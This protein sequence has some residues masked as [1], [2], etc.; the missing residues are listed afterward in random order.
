MFSIHMLPAA[1]GDCLW[2][3]YGDKNDPCRVLVDTGTPGTY[4]MLSQKIAP[5]RNKTFELFVVSHIDNDHIGGAIPL[6]ENPPHGI[7]FKD[8]WFNGFRHLIKANKDKLGFNQGQE[9]TQALVEGKH[10]WN[11]AFKC[12][13]V[14]VPEDGLLP[15]SKLDGN[16]KLTLLSPYPAQLEALLPDWKKA[17]IKLRKKEPDLIDDVAADHLGAKLN[18]RSLAES[19]FKEDAGTPNGS[20]I[21]FLAEYGSRAVLFGADAFPG[22]IEHSVDRLLAERKLRKLPLDAF[23]VCHHGSRHNTS[24]TLPAKLRAER[25]LISSDGTRHEHPHREGVARLVFYG[26]PGGTLVFNYATDYNRIWNDTLLKKDHKYKTAI[27]DKGNPG[28]LI[29]L[30]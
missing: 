24:P 12:G 27:P 20:S 23:K 30:G 13:P 19:P 4:E 16:L 8:V 22:V 18:I 11:K 10:P 25:Y 21:A 7:K 6:L 3:E 14:M 17:L 1:E 29:D 26:E 9:L 28:M 5:L 2:I 15:V